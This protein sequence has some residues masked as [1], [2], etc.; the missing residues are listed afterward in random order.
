MDG[1]HLLITIKMGI[2]FMGI[3]KVFNHQ[4][5]N[6]HDVNHS[7]SECVGFELDRIHV[8]TCIYQS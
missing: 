5:Y 6:Q 1:L 4:D 2:I 7:V 3:H 8:P